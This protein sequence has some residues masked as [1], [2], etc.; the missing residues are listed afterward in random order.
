MYSF[1]LNCLEVM[2]LLLVEKP[3]WLLCPTPQHELVQK[4]YWSMSSLL[5]TLASTVTPLA[6]NIVILGG[7]APQLAAVS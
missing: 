5:H 2:V 1:H 7:S 3:Q 6:V 4:N